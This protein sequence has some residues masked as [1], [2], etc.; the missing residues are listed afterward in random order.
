MNGPFEAANPSTRPNLPAFRPA[1]ATNVQNS[2]SQQNAPPA[3]VAFSPRRGHSD[4]DLLGPRRN[5]EARGGGN[6]GSNNATGPG[7]WTGPSSGLPNSPAGSL[8]ST[9]DQL[10]VWRTFLRNIPPDA[11]P[12][13][14][15]MAVQHAM[16]VAQRQRQQLQEGR[17]LSQRRR[18]SQT[19]RPTGIRPHA[20]TISNAGEFRNFSHPMQNPADPRFERP[21]PQ[22]PSP[23]SPAERRNDDYVLPPWQ[24]DSEVSEC[25]I[26]GRAFGLW[27]RKHH[28]RKCGRVVCANCSPHRITIP[29][30][31]IVHPPH[32]SRNEFN[33]NSI[34]VIDLSRDDDDDVQS[35]VSPHVAPSLG[36]GR[37]VRLCNPCVPDPNPLPPPSYANMLP[38]DS[39]RLQR[40]QGP[41]ARQ[42]WSPASPPMF[43]GP[44]NGPGSQHQGSPTVSRPPSMP[45]GDVH[46]GNRYESLIQIQASRMGPNSVTPVCLSLPSLLLLCT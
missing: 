7:G 33:A 27:F 22:A 32:E 18:S 3:N 45:G 39:S 42:S 6:N 5:S 23:T 31:Y 9:G 34:P 44:L 30:Q 28:C 41:H 36:G 10:E 46:P 20:A 8:E 25:P 29:T 24:P 13:Q 17:S 14:R 19:S 37:E 35:P 4:G 21:A 12:A 26:C 2:L 43:P 38:Y 1:S 11:D 15:T 16:E 40:R